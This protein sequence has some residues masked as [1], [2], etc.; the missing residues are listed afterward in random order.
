MTSMDYKF[1][2]SHL[3]S[4]WPGRFY[5]V[6]RLLFECVE[7][8]GWSAHNLYSLQVFSKCP[9]GVRQCGSTEK[10]R[11]NPLSGPPVVFCTKPVFSPPCLCSHHSVGPTYCCFLPPELTPQLFIH[12]FNKS[13]LSAYYVPDCGSRARHAWGNLPYLL[14]GQI[15]LSAHSTRACP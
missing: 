4:P 11:H 2:V 6:F 1:L 3:W 5:N 15:L 13:L 12:T 10:F 9:F 8:G 14:L 7:F